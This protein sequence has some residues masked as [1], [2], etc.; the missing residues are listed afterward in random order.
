MAL[1]RDRSEN[2]AGEGNMNIAVAHPGHGPR[3]RL[4]AAL[5]ARGLQVFSVPDLAGILDAASQAKL[6]IALVDPRLLAAADSDL[7]EQLRVRA[8]HSIQVIALTDRVTDETEAIFER[9]G[10]T[11]LEHPLEAIADVAAWTHELARRLSTGGR[12]AGTGGHWGVTGKDGGGQGVVLGARGSGATILV[13]EDE[14]S[15][16][17]FLCDA[18]G[19]AGYQ[20]WAAANAEDALAFFERAHVDLVVADINMPGMDGFELKQKLDLWRRAPVPFIMM[21]ADSNAQNAADAA[22]VGVVFILGK[23]IR[24]LEALYSIVRE[25]LRKGAADRH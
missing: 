4:A 5:R 25:T 24:N 18:L 13:V 9:H 23:P 20:V 7:R 21:T 1:R 17:M 10:A 22:A 6:V 2:P 14:P 11:L 12:D 19:E 8:G 16:R 3:E 15:F